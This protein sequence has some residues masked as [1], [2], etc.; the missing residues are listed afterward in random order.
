MELVSKEAVKQVRGSDLPRIGEWFWLR[1][2]SEDEESESSKE[3]LVCVE[4]V[5]SNHVVVGWTG[6]GNKWESRAKV[7]HEEWLSLTRPEAN[8]EAIITE[9]MAELRRQMDAKVKQLRLEAVAK[10]AITD[11]EAHAPAFSDTDAMLPAVRVV[12]PAKQKADFLALQQRLGV[13]EKEVKEL[14]EAY[15]GQARQLQLSQKFSMEQTVRELACLN[16]RIFVLEVY[17]GL[18]EAVIQIADGTP[19][20]DGTKIAVRQTMLFM[21]EETLVNYDFGGMD[22]RDIEKFDEWL[23]RPENLAR[24]LPEP[25]GIVAFRVRRNW[26]DYGE[27]TS[28]EQAL[29][30]ARWNIRNMETYLAIRNGEKVYRIA[31]AVNFS[32][33]LIPL[34]DEFEDAFEEKTFHGA[35]TGKEIGPQDLEYDDKVEKL[36]GRLRGYNK[37]TILLQGLLDRSDVFQ[38]IAPANLSTAS[39]FAATLE[40][41]RDEEGGLPLTQETFEEYRERLNGALKKGDWVYIA[42]PSP[43]TKGNTRPE[44]LR[45]E[46]IRPGRASD[47]TMSIFYKDMSRRKNPAPFESAEEIEGVMGVEVSWPWG[48]RWGYEHGDWG[49]YGEWKVNRRR[50]QW[51]P[52]KNVF[53]I[54]AYQ[55]GDYMK[56]LCDRSQKGQ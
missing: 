30:H 14:A 37:I 44:V 55:I 19:A 52:L 38:P 17:A 22:F 32:P 12:E 45:A 1:V 16:D 28:I 48:T 6:L 35:K 8:W 13:V 7:R 21:D 39:D 15:A 23:V 26:K 49:R 29:T 51:I 36:M 4:R 41:I 33:R 31:S 24:I 10:N 27:A 5:R 40:L 47:V 18:Q 42:Y 46:R 53:N 20:P 3:V 2:S 43:E 50:H 54:E 34:R 11:E 25:R 56:F 9:R